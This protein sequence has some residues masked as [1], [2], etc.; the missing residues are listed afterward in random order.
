MQVGDAF[1]T[2]N[3]RQPRT[4]LIH[5]ID[6]MKQLRG[7]GRIRD[8]F[9]LVVQVLEAVVGVEIDVSKQRVFVFVEEI[10]EEHPQTLAEDVGVGYLHHGGFEVEGQQHVFFLCVLRERTAPY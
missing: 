1:G 4:R 2:V 10:S 9:Q 7:D 6:L 8:Q 5:L 3:H